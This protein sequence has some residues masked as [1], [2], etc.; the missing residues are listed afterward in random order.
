MTFLELEKICKKR[1]LIARI[2][3]FIVILLII[4]ILYLLMNA[5]INFKSANLVDNKSE[6]NKTSNEKPEDISVK[7]D[8]N[9]KHSEKKTKKNIRKEKMILTAVLDL[10]I[11]DGNIKKV[12]KKN[13]TKTD[14]NKVFRKN[15]IKT[16]ENQKEKNLLSTRNLPS[17][18]TCIALS[19]KYY[20]EKNYKKAL[21]WAKNANL[22]NNKKV[23]SWILSAKALYKL[24]RKKE[25][26]KI[27]KIYYNYRKDEKVKKLLGDLYEKGN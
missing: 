10:N 26:I 18:E 16:S 25:A 11:S 27:L 14:E 6:H 15:V 23:D 17:Y 1:R 7:S 12:S 2:V 20:S 4:S 24:G 3:Y 13:T 5:N 22:L 8:K 21:Y 19:E 9:I